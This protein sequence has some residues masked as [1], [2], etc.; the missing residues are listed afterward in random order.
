MTNKTVYP[1]RVDSDLKRAFI[2]SAKDNDRSGAQ[3]IRD[4]MRDY[5]RRNNQ[6][7]LKL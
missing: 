2:S 7:S 1:L 6:K 4:F 3:L 5:I